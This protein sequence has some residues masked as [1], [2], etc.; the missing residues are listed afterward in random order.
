MERNDI[1]MI[2]G[3]NYKEMTMKLLEH[4]DLADNICGDLDF[5]E[6][7]N[8]VSMDRILAFKDPVLCDSFAAEIMG[9]EPH[10][11]EYI[12]LAEKLGVGSTDTKKVE[13]HALNREAETVKPAA[14]EGRAAKL[15]AY[16]KPKNA[17]SACYGSLIYALD[18]LNEQG[19]LD[20]KK[21]KSLAIGQGYQK[22]H[23]MYGIGN[24]TA[25]FEKHVDGCPPKAV[26]IVRFLK[27]EWD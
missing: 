15:A 19:L 24:C 5:E 22:K 27:E 7:G 9:Y 23:G 14:P 16:V 21:K 12:H 13:I 26:D 17:C 4:I 3:T 1:Y 20:H 25:C 18:R 8:P 6:G 2:Q 10:D 11:V